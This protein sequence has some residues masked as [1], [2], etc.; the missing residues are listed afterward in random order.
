M[1]SKYSILFFLLLAA[2]FLFQGTT[3]DTEFPPLQGISVGM[4]APDIALENPSGKVMKLSSL[5]G[6]VVLIDFWASWCG[7]CRRENPNIV[8][9]YQKYQK[10]KFKDAKGFEVF[11]VSLD[12]NVKAWEQAID[13]DDLDWKYH[14]SD[15]KKWRSEPAATY[16]VRSIPSNFLIDQDGVI[17]GKNLRGIALDQ[18]LD[19][20]ITSL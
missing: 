15:L 14:V 1:T 8:R 10:A 2:P 16:G 4:K 20:L 13:K 7:P 12:N 18:A 3:D 6:K 19:G 17:I 11:S 9:A 5:R